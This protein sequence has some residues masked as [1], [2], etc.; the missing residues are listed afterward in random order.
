LVLPKPTDDGCDDG[1]PVPTQTETQVLTQ[2]EVELFSAGGTLKWTRADDRVL[3]DYF[4]TMSTQDAMCCVEASMGSA[5]KYHNLK[6]VA[7]N[8]VV[9]RGF[10]RLEAESDSTCWEHTK[11]GRCARQQRCQW[12]HI[13]SVELQLIIWG[14]ETAHHFVE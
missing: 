14:A 2:L 11:K 5:L 13:Q 7:P 12:N 8:A 10:S 1:T 3:C 4:T 9:V 6:Q